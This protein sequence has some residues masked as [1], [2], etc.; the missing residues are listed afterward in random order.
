VIKLVPAVTPVTT[1]ALSIVA[2]AVVPDDHGV[3]PTGPDPVKVVVPVTHALNVPVMIGVALIVT[4][5]VVTQPLLLVYVIKLVPA[6]TPVTKPAFDIV[7]TPGVPDDHGVAPAG[8]DPVSVVV[9]VIHALNVPVMIGVALIVTI[10]VV[11][12]P[13]LLV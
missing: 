1:P 9:P 4:I 13:L 3:A 11:T 7:A 8:P 10:A 5:A 12:Q 6:V 2:T